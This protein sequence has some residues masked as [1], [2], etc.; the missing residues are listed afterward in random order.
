MT[1]AAMVYRLAVG[2]TVLSVAGCRDGMTG[3]AL[4][5]V[6]AVVSPAPGASEVARDGPV[7]MDVPM[8]MDTAGCAGRMLLHVGDSLGP[9]VPTH[10]AFADGGRR[11]AIHPDPVLAP[12]TTYFVHVHDSMA[13]AGGTGMMRGGMCASCRQM[14]VLEPPAGAVRMGGGVG[15]AFTTGP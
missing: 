15:W 7:T 3:V 9:L 12:R 13:T 11:M 5:P 10:M 14:M 2:A 8:A 4:I 6:A 1:I